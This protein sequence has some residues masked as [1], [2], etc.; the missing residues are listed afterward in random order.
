MQLDEYQAETAAHAAR[1]ALILLEAKERLQQQG[2]LTAL[3]FSG[4]VHALQVIAENSIG[5]AKHSLKA[6]G[7]A[8]P[9][10]AYD[11][12]ALLQQ[13]GKLSMDEL[14]AWQR[15]IDLRNRIV[16]DYLNLDTRVIYRLIDSNAY[17]FMLDFFIEPFNSK[18]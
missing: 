9:V 1:Q 8:V 12:F 17:Q 4:A 11:C 5:K 3:E 2:S 15:A 10:S 13:A 16:H 18:A 7:Q 6:L 14:Q